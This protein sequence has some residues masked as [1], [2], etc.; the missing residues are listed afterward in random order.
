MQTQTSQMNAVSNIIGLLK[1]EGVQQ[2][3]LNVCVE[4]NL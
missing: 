1:Y 3:S 2:S 4:I